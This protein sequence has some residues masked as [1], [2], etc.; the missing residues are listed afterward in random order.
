SPVYTAVRPN[1]ASLYEPLPLRSSPELKSVQL[2]AYKIRD[3]L[4][5]VEIE[6][7][8]TWNT[9]FWEKF[10][11]LESEWLKKADQ[12]LYV[13]FP[14]DSKEISIPLGLT[15]LPSTYRRHYRPLAKHLQDLNRASLKQNYLVITV[16]TELTSADESTLFA[17]FWNAMLPSMKTTFIKLDSPDWENDILR[18]T[19]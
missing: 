9:H 17:T 18:A 7:A 1:Y 6:P 5:V 10:R 14:Y 19:A 13:T 16:P 15:G 3:N 2:Q 4:H 12:I 8:K 11:E